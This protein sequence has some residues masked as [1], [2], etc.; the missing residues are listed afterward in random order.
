MRREV[1]V[2]SSGGA[3]L[4][5]GLVALS[6]HAF[7]PAPDSGETVGATPP[8]VVREMPSLVGVAPEIQRVL[9]ERGALRPATRHD[10]EELPARVVRVLEIRRTPLTVPADPAQ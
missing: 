5:A 7:G 8:P 4:I 2:A 1:L 3:V 10:L 9:Y 6:S